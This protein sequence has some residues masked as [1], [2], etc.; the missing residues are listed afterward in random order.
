MLGDRERWDEI[1]TK[2]H[3]GLDPSAFLGALLPHLPGGNGPTGSERNYALDVA[4]GKGPDALLLARV[5]Y[6]VDA[7][8]V[9]PVA[10]QI[11]NERALMEGLDARITPQQVDLSEAKLPENAYDLVFCRR[12]L[13]RALLPQLRNAVKIGGALVL[14]L[15]TEEQAQQPT[16]PKN[17]AYLLRHGEI[18]DLLPASH[19]NIVRWYEEGGSLHQSCLAGIA[20][21]RFF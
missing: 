13:D 7:L 6:V 9:S 19:F 1:H 14:E 20:G 10:L 2:S 12:F 16:G 4:C 3:S 8:D 17:P 15:F 11:L 18:R 5:G 21:I